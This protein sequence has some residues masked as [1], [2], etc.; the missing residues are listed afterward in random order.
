MCI[1]NTQILVNVENSKFTSHPLLLYQEQDAD[2]D[3]SHFTCRFSTFPITQATWLSF[4]YITQ[5]LLGHYHDVVDVIAAMINPEAQ[6]NDCFPNSHSQHICSSKLEKEGMRQARFSCSVGF[7]SNLIKN[8]Q[9]F[10][11]VPCK[12]YVSH[13][14]K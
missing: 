8:I 3:S 14:L 12:L 9:Q 7:S 10:T 5:A 2:H 4:P 1:F 13:A 6:C 11:E